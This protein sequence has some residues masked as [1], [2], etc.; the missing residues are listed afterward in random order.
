MR[1]RELMEILLDIQIQ[2]EKNI[3][4]TCVHLEKKLKSDDLLLKFKYYID[5]SSQFHGAL[6]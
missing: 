5:L 6:F 4:E 2:R 1:K 3:P